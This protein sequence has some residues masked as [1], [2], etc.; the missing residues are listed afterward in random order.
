MCVCFCMC[1]HVL[2]VYFPMPLFGKS[3]KSLTFI[4]YSNQAG[5]SFM[6]LN[7]IACLF[8]C[9]YNFPPLTTMVPGNG[10]HSMKNNIF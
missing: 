7:N 2:M 1:V 4:P 5:V 10:R 8:S 6:F 9:Y 3:S